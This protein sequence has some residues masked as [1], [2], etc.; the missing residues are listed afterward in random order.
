MKLLV[1]FSAIF[2]VFIVS[3]V[4]AS[5]SEDLSVCCHCPPPEPFPSKCIAVSCLP[6]PTTQKPTVRCCDCPRPNKL[7][8]ICD[9]VRCAGC[10]TKKPTGGC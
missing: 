5:D 8:A 6:C 2:A 9:T 10:P 1:I 3:I 7:P 4:R